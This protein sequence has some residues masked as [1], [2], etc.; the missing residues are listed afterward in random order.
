MSENAAIK[1]AIV[2]ILETLPS[3][4]QM[5]VQNFVESLQAK[6]PIKRTRKSL[7]GLWADLEIDITDEDIAEV[8]QEMWGSFPKDMES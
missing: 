3:D 4:K 5:E 2:N 8:R 6:N 1:Q 7:K